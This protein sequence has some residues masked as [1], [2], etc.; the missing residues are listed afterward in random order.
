LKILF[1]GQHFAPEDVSGS[2]LATELAVD[3]VKRGHE[4]TFVTCA[5]NYPKGKVF[6]GYR[7]SLVCQEEIDGVRVI[8]IWSYITTKK[9]FWPRIFNYGTFSLNAFWGGLIAGKHDVLINFTPPLP[10]GISAYLL[11]R[12]WNIPW[13]LRV[14]D[15]YPDAAISAG[16]LKNKIAISF[17]YML[18]KFLYKKAKTLLTISDG[19]NEIIVN[20]GIP[21]EKMSVIP[22]WADT[23][24]VY[25]QEK[26]N[27]FRIENN[28]TG[29][30]VLLYTGNLGFASNLEDVILA[31]DLLRDDPDIMF[32]LLGEGVKKNELMELTEKKMLKNIKFLPYQPRE[33]FPMVLASAD[34]GLVTLNAS[35]GIFSLPSKTFNVMAS[36]RPVL[37]IAPTGSDIDQL[38]SSHDIGINV[39]PGNPRL[40]AD[41]IIQLKRD[42]D[43]RAQMGKRA[44]FVCE[45][46]YSRGHCIALYEKNIEAALKG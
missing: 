29:S 18:E 20:K 17:F 31:A 12:L 30:F 24:F 43:R 45:E 32:V 11:G 35:S 27:A 14:S 33:K 6:K 34:V 2:V 38:V 25:P 21:A 36:G 1:L 19:F 13:L 3:L 8:R 40:L 4:V 44:R 10:L 23:D 28:L 15:I 5:P 39:P 7:N 9:S 22:V 26:E 16:V 41:A 46:F 42:R 37:S